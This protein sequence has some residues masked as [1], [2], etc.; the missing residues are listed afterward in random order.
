MVRHLV[1]PARARTAAKPGK[2]PR[3]SNTTKP[4]PRTVLLKHGDVELNNEARQ[5]RP[6]EL[7]VPEKRQSAW[8][9]RIEGYSPREIAKALDVTEQ[10]IYQLIREYGAD[11]S[12]YTEAS[13]EEFRTMEL[14]R[15]DKLLV[16]HWKFREF[17]KNATVILNILERKHK[18]LGIE[19]THK[20]VT[21]EQ[22]EVGV[23]FANLDLTKLS[24]EELGWL[25]IIIEKALPHSNVIDAQYTALPAPAQGSASDGTGI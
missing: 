8:D 9:L 7:T 5:D 25:E 3:K 23:S 11:L 20:H 4:T 21:V 18:L 1:Y 24:N 15:L 6:R 22:P 13:K 19:S 12:K 14:A 10:R 2:K 17:T 16:S